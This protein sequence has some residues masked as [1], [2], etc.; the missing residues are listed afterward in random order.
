MS[1][2]SSKKQKTSS[3][4]V[5][6]G[7]SWGDEGKG[8]LV[9]FL[10]EAKKMDVC[11]R[12]NGGNN[13]G[14]SIE[15][16]GKTFHVHLLPSGVLTPSCVNV[17]GNGMVIHL[18]SLF[19]ELASLLEGGVDAEKSVRVSLRAQIVFDFHKIVDGAREAALGDKQLGT[20]KR[21]IGPSYADKAARRGLRIAEFV[22]ARDGVFE[23]KFRDLV[24][25]VRA[26]HPAAFADYDADAELATL[27][28]LR[29]RV[30]AM[31]CDTSLLVN[32]AIADGQSVLLEGANAV[33]LDIDHGTYPFVTSSS[34]SVAGAALGVGIP[35]RAIGDV[36][37]VVKAY[38]TRVGAGPFPTELAWR[39]A[40]T[41]G[42]HLQRV[43]HEYGTTTGRPRRCG[44]L[45]LNLVAYA[46]RLNGFTSINVTKLDVLS[47]LASLQ[48]GVAYMLD[49]ARLPFGSLPASLDDLARCEVVY[50][51]FDGWTDDISQCTARADLPPAAERYLA[52]IEEL[53]GLPAPWI[54][55]GAGRTQT[56]VDERY[57]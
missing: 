10:L 57:K 19:A 48:L 4:S 26:E 20:T 40:G 12:F 11:A 55:V 29:E 5:V 56:L 38:T 16:D 46:H 41:P 43:G 53:L 54:G 31:A 30:R 28:T 27:L 21:G 39:E 45:D 3:C 36:I 2:Q 15:F 50:E 25:I 8:K 6:L 18:P 47:G 52:R 17:L 33:L 51:S 23:S 44:W 7:S 13:A 24:A 1:D 34:P 35:P 37:G 9:D 22:D 42:E 49:G 32:A 14:H